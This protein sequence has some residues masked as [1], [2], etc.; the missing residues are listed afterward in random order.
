MIRGT[1][2]KRNTTAENKPKLLT[3][4]RYKMRTSGYSNK[5]IKAYIH[6]IK[7]F[8]LFNGT[9]HPRELDKESIE[10]FLTHI[11]VNKN[12]TASTQ[13]QALHTILYLHK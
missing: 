12:V 10:K 8:I 6:W 13:N 11:A 1:K 7:K 2:T 5:T 4:V 9:K 3:E